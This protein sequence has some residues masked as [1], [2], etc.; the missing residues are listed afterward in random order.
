MWDFCQWLCKRVEFETQY[1]WH[2]IITNSELRAYLSD[3]EL[4]LRSYLERDNV[5]RPF[6]RRIIEGLSQRGFVIEEKT[7]EM[8]NIDGKE[9][10][11]YQ[12]RSWLRENCD[13][14]RKYGT[15]DIDDINTMD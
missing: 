4:V 11:E 2:D 3:R 6:L 12:P 8:S 13:K 5:Y 1:Y 15:A 14:F 9:I 7:G 10:I